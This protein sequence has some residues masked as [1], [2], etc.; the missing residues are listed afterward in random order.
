MTNTQAALL[1][2]INRIIIKINRE[3]ELR[4]EDS[5][6]IDLMNHLENTIE[7]LNSEMG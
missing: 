4:P 6:M 1:E 7:V 3:L 2:N 5:N